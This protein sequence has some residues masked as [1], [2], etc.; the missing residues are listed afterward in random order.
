MTSLDATSRLTE[1]QHG[2][3]STLSA[4][5]TAAPGHFHD[6]HRVTARNLGLYLCQRS[7]P[8]VLYAATSVDPVPLPAM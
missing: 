4:L 7:A 6:L 8:S 5:S 3:P 1:P 2:F